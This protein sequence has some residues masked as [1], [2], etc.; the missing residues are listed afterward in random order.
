MGGRAGASGVVKVVVV[1]APPPDFEP[2]RSHQGPE[3]EPA[4]SH[5]ARE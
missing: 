4:R 5:D 1:V 2:A 3:L